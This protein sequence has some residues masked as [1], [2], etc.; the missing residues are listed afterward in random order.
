MKTIR[1]LIADESVFIRQQLTKMLSGHED[2]TVIGGAANGGEAVVKVMDLYPSVVLMGCGMPLVSGFEALVK[3]RELTGIPVIMTI[4]NRKHPEEDHREATKLGAA[5]CIT[6]RAALLSKDIEVLK[7]EL[8]MKIR[9]VSAEYEAWKK[10][11]L[12]PSHIQTLAKPKPEPAVP[13]KAPYSRRRLPPGVIS[14]IIIGISTGG[15]PALQ[16]VVSRLPAELPVPVIVVQHI[17]AEFTQP[18]ARRLNTMARLDVVEARHGMRLT[19]GMIVLAP[20]GR[21]MLIMPDKT[22]AVSHDVFDV[23][24]CPSIDITAGSI[25]DVYGSETLGVMMTGMGNDGLSG[26][27]KIHQAGGYILAQDEASSVVYGMPKAVI[28]DAIVQ[29]IHSLTDLPEA[30]ASC[31]KLHACAP[32]AE[33]RPGQ[34]F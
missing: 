26:F 16:E 34:H 24:Y 23:P 8:I 2:I 27:R 7:A 28:D 19:G 21:Q 9:R 31:F 22:I 18:L 12:Q 10:N 6:H 30:I 14:I 15:P 4:I 20:G 17:P 3:I 32:A 29:E 5:D 13:I 33:K 25:V 11:N 1:V